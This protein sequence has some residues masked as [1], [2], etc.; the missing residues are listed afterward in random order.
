MKLTLADAAWVGGRHAVLGAPERVALHRHLHRQA[1]V[2]DDL[3]QRL[4][5]QELGHGGQRAVLAERVPRER[6][7]LLDQALCAHVEEGGHF[8]E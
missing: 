4:D 2:E 1:A 6:R 5:G 7:T 8:E 3:D